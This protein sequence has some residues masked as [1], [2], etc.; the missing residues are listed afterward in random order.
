MCSL[1]N[2]QTFDHF[3]QNENLKNFELLFLKV[4]ELSYNQSTSG[5]RRVA[6]K[7]RNA[8][9]LRVAAGHGDAAARSAGSGGS[10]GAGG[11]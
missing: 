7:W 4:C 8:E 6:E 9:P 2:E 3:V 1:T 11:R 10:P 5:V